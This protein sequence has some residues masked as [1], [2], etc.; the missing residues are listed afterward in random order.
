MECQSA[1]DVLRTLGAALGGTFP[2]PSETG[3][4]IPGKTVGSGHVVNGYGIFCIDIS[5]RGG[6]NHVRRPSARIAEC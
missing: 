5:K 1:L 6:S 3:F 4:W 2:K